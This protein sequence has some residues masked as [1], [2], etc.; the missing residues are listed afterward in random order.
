MEQNVQCIQMETLLVYVPLVGLETIASSKIHVRQRL[1]LMAESA[2]ALSVE[3]LSSMNVVVQRV[4]EVRIVRSSTPVPLT[5]AR[6]VPAAPIGMAN[7]TVLA[8]QDTR[9]A[10]AVWILMN[11]EHPASAKM[12]DSALTPLVLSAVAA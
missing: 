1:V 3:E 10:A 7:T 9:A 11:A 6:M 4:L 5:H 12:E 2:V 8:R